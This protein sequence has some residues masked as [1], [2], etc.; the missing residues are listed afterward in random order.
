MS[1][2][3]VSSLNHK[4]NYVY[5]VKLTEFLT[6]LFGFFLFS[7]ALL[8]VFGTDDALLRSFKWISMT[9]TFFCRH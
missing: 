7:L 2:F 9:V 8:L 5:F 4:F 1:V 3:R 6:P